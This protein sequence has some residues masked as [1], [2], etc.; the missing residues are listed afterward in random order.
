MAK[1]LGAVKA[2]LTG[3]LDE[4]LGAEITRLRVG[5]GWTQQKLSE[6]TGYDESYI[7]QLERGR[8]SPTVR[9]LGNIATA[10]SLRG[11]TVLRSAERR[12]DRT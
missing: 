4:A 5:R 1:P 6:I 8:K 12:M 9:T 3:S 7:R 11:S 10:L 2:R